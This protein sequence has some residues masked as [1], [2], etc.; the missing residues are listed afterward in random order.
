[1][2]A[3]HHFL[4][5]EISLANNSMLERLNDI[6]EPHRTLLPA[7]KGPTNSPAAA[8]DG[9]QFLATINPGGDYGKR[10]LSATLRN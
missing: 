8:A 1:M 7:E 5:D 9:F 2:K 6:L 4:L 10:E 3:G